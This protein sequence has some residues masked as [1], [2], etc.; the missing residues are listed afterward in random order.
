MHGSIIIPHFTWI[1]Q[2]F[3]EYFCKNSVFFL[4]KYN[5]MQ[6]KMSRYREVDEKQKIIQKKY[7]PTTGDVLSGEFIK[8]LTL[9]ALQETNN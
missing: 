4:Q 3:F 8:Y 2:A 6:K 7:P 9:F 1:K 5:F